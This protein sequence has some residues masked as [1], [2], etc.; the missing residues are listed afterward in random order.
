MLGQALSQH[1][2][3]PEPEMIHEDNAYE[4]YSVTAKNN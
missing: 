4:L 3:M 1:I 2:Y